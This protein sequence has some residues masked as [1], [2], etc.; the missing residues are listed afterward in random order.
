MT[1]A[2]SGKNLPNSRFVVKL[3]V[4]KSSVE[5]CVTPSSRPPNPSVVMRPVRFNVPKSDSCTLRAPDAAHPPLL[6]D[7]SSRSSFTQT[8]PDFAAAERFLTP[9]SMVFTSPMDGFPMMEMRLLGRSESYSEYSRLYEAVPLA[10]A[11]FLAFFT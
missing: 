8:S 3:Y 11:M 1:F 6:F 7:S 4:L 5:R 2:L 10:L 9:M